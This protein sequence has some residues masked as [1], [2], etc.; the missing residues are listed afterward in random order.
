MKSEYEVHKHSRGCVC[1]SW[2]I[3]ETDSSGGLELKRAVRLQHNGAAEAVHRL[4]SQRG[5]PEQGESIPVL[6][7]AEEAASRM[8][9]PLHGQQKTLQTPV[10][11]WRCILTCIQSCFEPLSFHMHVLLSCNTCHSFKGGDLA[12]F[13]HEG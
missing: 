9:S 12:C 11:I 3:Q 4:S 7:W 13:K 8:S 5:W 2:G 6:G 10:F 1:G